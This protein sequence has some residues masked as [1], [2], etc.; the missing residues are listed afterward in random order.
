MRDYVA[1]YPG[2]PVTIDNNGDITFHCGSIENAYEFSKCLEKLEIEKKI[3]VCE[4]CNKEFTA[5]V[6]YTNEDDIEEW[7]VTCPHCKYKNWLGSNCYY[8]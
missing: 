2:V 3:Y 8:R 5:D 6:E 7:Y 4:E 1:T